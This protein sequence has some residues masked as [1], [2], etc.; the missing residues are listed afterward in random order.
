MV[1][2]HR[3]PKGPH[4]H[5]HTPDSGRSTSLSES[6]ETCTARLTCSSAIEC[7]TESSIMARICLTSSW[8][9][10]L[11]QN[12]RASSRRRDGHMLVQK[13]CPCQ[14]MPCSAPPALLGLGI[15]HGTLVNHSTHAKLNPPCRN[16]ASSAAQQSGCVKYAQDPDVHD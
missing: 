12:S 4:T 10:P 14:P 15:I 13:T 8:C 3:T 11:A 2:Q 7:H 16:R 9:P 5:T 6:G 1:L